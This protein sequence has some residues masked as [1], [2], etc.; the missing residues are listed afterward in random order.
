[1]GAG[2]DAVQGRSA[3]CSLRACGFRSGGGRWSGSGRLVCVRLMVVLVVL[4]VV[5]S[6]G[7]VVLSWRGEL[8]GARFA[9]GV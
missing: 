6:G 9:G 2:G 1:M 4:A 5:D 8:G 3:G 7:V